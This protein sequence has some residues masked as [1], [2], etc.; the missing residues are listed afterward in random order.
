VQFRYIQDDCVQQSHA[1]KRLLPLFE[2]NLWIFVAILLLRSKDQSQN[3]TLAS[4]A[5]CLC[6]KKSGH[7]WTANCM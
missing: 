3:N 4:F 5:T 1:V 2:V 7:D 6:R